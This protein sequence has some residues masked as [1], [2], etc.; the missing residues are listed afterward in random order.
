MSSSRAVNVKA[1]KNTKEKPAQRTSWPATREE[2]IS[3]PRQ[4]RKDLPEILY[5]QS[6]VREP[7]TPV[8]KA[9]SLDLEPPREAT[10][11]LVQPSAPL[12]PV[13]VIDNPVEA[14]G[15]E[16]EEDQEVI[17]N[18]V[19]FNQPL[20]DQ[21]FVPDPDETSDMNDD[22]FS[23]NAFRGRSDESG[24]EWLRHFENYCAYKGYDKPKSL[25][26]IKVLLAGNAANWFDTLNQE[27]REDYDRLVAVFKLR[28]KPPETMKF[29]SAK[30]LYSRRQR[31]DETVDNYIESMR[32]LGREIREGDA[33]EEMTRYAILNGLK[34]NIANFVTQREP[35]TMDELV[36]AARLAELTCNDQMAE[37]KEEI[38]RLA[39]RWDN[40]TAAPLVNRSPSPVAQERRVSFIDQYNDR[41][42][43]DYAASDDR[44]RSQQTYLPGARPF[45]GNIQRQRGNYG[46]RYTTRSRGMGGGFMTGNYPPSQEVQRCN[47]CGRTAHT[48]MLQCPANTRTCNAC[49]RRGHFA[50]VCRAAMR[51]RLGPINNGNPRRGGSY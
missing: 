2:V 3:K 6:P 49:H 11:Q 41:R 46:G 50:V 26:L 10:A 16:E 30:E 32:K 17:L 24:E 38:K 9:A 36:K 18:P 4:L 29:K 43:G 48:N 22:R 7:V 33:G 1:Q 15:E 35:T 5:R 21:V 20:D 23:P 27:D 19:L 37:V 44:W 13:G 28:Y 14:E 34:A 42:A 31:D 12:E 47:K 39:I 45:R 25:S 51:G 40:M 8:R